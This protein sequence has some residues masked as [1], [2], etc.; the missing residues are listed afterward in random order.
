MPSRKGMKLVVESQPE[1]RVPLPPPMPAP[2]G[3]ICAPHRARM[4]VAIQAH[5]IINGEPFC[6]ICYRGQGPSLN[7]QS[8]VQRRGQQRSPGVTAPSTLQII[9]HLR[10]RQASRGKPNGHVPARPPEQRTVLNL[11]IRAIA[12]AKMYP[13]A[14]ERGCPDPARE[15]AREYVSFNYVAR[16]RI[17]LRHNPRL[18][19]EVSR[20]RISL[21]KAYCIVREERRAEQPSPMPTLEGTLAEKLMQLAVA[22]PNARDRKDKHRGIEE[23]LKA[24][25]VCRR[26]FG[27]ARLILRKRPDLAERILKGEIT[28]PEATAIYQRDRKAPP[29]GSA[30]ER[31]SDF[32]LTQR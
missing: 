25:G 23:T 29:S 7:A 3:V 11:G 1:Y 10:K 4:G 16:A 13:R 8:L 21:E 15:A 20:S 26:Y 14:T 6:R 18:A 28:L 32:L 2:P 27:Q 24:I 19:D 5:I 30:Q 9:E 31:S 12:I 17:V 22:F